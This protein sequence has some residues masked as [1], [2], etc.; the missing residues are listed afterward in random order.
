MLLKIQ[1]RYE[2]LCMA[3]LELSVKSDCLSWQLDSATVA[4]PSDV[5]SRLL[6]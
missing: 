5:R 6:R 4:L 2:H 3:K 1:Q